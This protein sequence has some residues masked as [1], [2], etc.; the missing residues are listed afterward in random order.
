PHAVPR[1]LHELDALDRTG[2]VGAAQVLVQVRTQ[3]RRPEVDGVRVEVDQAAREDALGELLYT[4]VGDGGED[5]VG[6]RMLRVRQH[7]VADPRDGRARH[8]VAQAPE[9]VAPVDRLADR[10]LLVA[11]HSRADCYLCLQELA[12]VAVMYRRMS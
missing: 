6:L 11:R 5:A 7:G 12:T 4:R 8:R 2:P 9:E 3:R 1:E 10:R